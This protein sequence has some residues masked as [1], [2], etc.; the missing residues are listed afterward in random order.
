MACHSIGS[1]IHL[2]C[3]DLYVSWSDYSQKIERSRFINQVEIQP[4]RLLAGVDYG[5]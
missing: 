3:Q 2:L 4:N 1:K 5:W